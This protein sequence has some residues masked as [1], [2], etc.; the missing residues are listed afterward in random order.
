[1]FMPEQIAHLP[2]VTTL[3]NVEVQ[4]GYD[5]HDVSVITDH[6]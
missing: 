6:P 3:D 1:M 4:V 5:T 2:P